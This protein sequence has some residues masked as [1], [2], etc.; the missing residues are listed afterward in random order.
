[1][2]TGLII[3]IV[4]GLAF[5][6][7]VT[8]MLAT[9]F[10]N[11]WPRGRRF[12]A[13]QGA[14]KLTLIVSEQAADTFSQ[15][16]QKVAQS[17]AKALWS[18]AMAFKVRKQGDPQKLAEAAVL[19]QHDGEFETMAPMGLQ[20]AAAYQMYVRRRI[21]HGPILIVMR[22]SLVTHSLA[23]GEPIIHELIHAV[24][25]D[26]HHKD[27]SWWSEHSQAPESVQAYAR[28]RYLT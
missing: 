21:G 18:T 8:F 22:A 25:G 20:G 17:Y 19:I 27:E 10:R 2:E 4:T 3:L 1:M 26:Y 9:G 16:P 7:M 14:H 24:G 12:E 23:R 5:A 13:A 28:E 11:Q 15:D 6:A